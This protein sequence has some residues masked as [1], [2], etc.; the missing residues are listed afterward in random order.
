MS[1][2]VHAVPDE[3]RKSAHIDAATYED[4][5]RRSI[6][7]PEA[8]WREEARRIDWMQPFNTV[9]DTRF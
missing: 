1:E 3:W 7:D 8:F 2:T 9:K 6:D 5:Y 4:K